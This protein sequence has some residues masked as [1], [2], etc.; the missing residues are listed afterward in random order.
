MPCQGYQGSVVFKA[1]LQMEGSWLSCWRVRPVGMPEGHPGKNEGAWRKTHVVEVNPL[2]K[3][4]RWA[5]LSEIQ[6]SWASESMTQQIWQAASI[7][8]SWVVCCLR[9][10]V[11]AAS[12]HADC[13]CFRTKAIFVAHKCF[14]V[15]WLAVSLPC[16]TI[17]LLIGV[18]N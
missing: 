4:V 2:C 8:A 15:D 10:A 5:D 12:L 7:V 3:G 13:M 1:Q 11:A 14:I 18:E 16:I 6:T 17:Y 9:V